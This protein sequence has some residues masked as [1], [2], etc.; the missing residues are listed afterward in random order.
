M[1]NFA[2][3]VAMGKRGVPRWQFLVTSAVFVALFGVVGIGLG[4]LVYARG[5][6]VDG[7]EGG[8]ALIGVVRLN[9]QL[10]YV[11]VPDL[12]EKHIKKQ[13]ETA[14]PEITEKINYTYKGLSNALTPVLMTENLKEGILADIKAGKKLFIKPN[15]VVPRTL[16]LAGDGTPGSRASV[17]AC[18]DWAFIAALMRFFHDDLGIRYYQMALGEAGTL[19]PAYSALLK[20]TPEALIEGCGFKRPDGTPYHAGWCMNWIR[21]YLSE[22]TK[23]LDPK[24]DPLNGYMDSIEGNYVT[25]GQATRDGKLMVYDLNN[26]EWFDRGRRVDVPDGGDN[27]KEGIVLHKAIVGD[28][29]D[30]ENYPGCVL[31]NAPIL[32]VH[33]ITIITNAIKNLGIGAWPMCAGNDSDAKTCD[34]LYSYP[35]DSPPGLKGGVPGWAGTVPWRG[36]GVYHD[37]WYVTEAN[38]EGLPLKITDKPNMG[39]DGTMV[40]I[41]LAIQ[42]QVPHMLHVVDAVNIIDIEHGGRGS[43]VPR[44]EG[45]ILASTDPVAL[46]LLCSRYM[47]KNLPRDPKS[48]DQFAR[49]VPVPRYDAGAKAIITEPGVDHRVTR[50]KLFD[51]AARRR[52]GK[53]N[54]FVAGKDLTVATPAALVSKEGH[55][56]RTED[57][58]FVDLVTQNLYFHQ[59]NTLWDLQ[60]SALAYAKAT[61]ALTG[62]NYNDEFMVLDEDG[63]GVID[64]RECGKDGMWD[65]V[66]GLTGIGCSMM[67]KGEVEPGIIFMNSRLL[68]FA[69]PTWN[70][71]KVAPLKTFLDTIAFPLALRLATDKQSSGADLF[72]GVSFGASDGKPKWPSL[73]FARYALEQS[74]LYDR[75]YP[76]AE[77]FSKKTGK[78]FKLYV[79]KG[80]PYAPPSPP[81][82]PPWGYNPKGLPNVV[83]LDPTNP[84]YSKLVFSVEFSEM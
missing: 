20:C 47:F 18:T 55:F 69:D 82:K 9:P 73:Q 36:G 27:Y 64:D 43:G 58:K 83:E 81:G 23:P 26:A 8:G 19:M 5:P 46:D 39:I 41:A 71:G 56:G 62:S 49:S 28:P 31:V 15:L 70:T 66:V 25:P 48:P 12:L 45:L 59:S 3:G 38:E 35:P 68:K 74:I 52:L 51:Y 72:F 54:Y 57:G 78:T 79:P 32:K 76:T 50:C 53:V 33:A 63:N 75:I 10:S 24:D 80:V 17:Y 4:G 7:P 6:E 42:G 1:D 34:W 60:A 16:D 11:G 29:A 77:V 67:G 13:D 61:D 30:P 21:K 65:C 84:D 22:T 44:E 2:G 40:D 37:R 14:W